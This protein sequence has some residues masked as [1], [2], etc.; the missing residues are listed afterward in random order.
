MLSHDKSNENSVPPHSLSEWVNHWGTLPCIKCSLCSARQS[1]LCNKSK[2]EALPIVVRQSAAMCGIARAAGN[3]RVL[4]GG[5]YV[6]CRAFFLPVAQ[7]APASQ[8]TRLAGAYPAPPVWTMPTC[9]SYHQLQWH[10][11]GSLLFSPVFLMHSH[12]IVYY[13]MYREEKNEFLE[14]MYT[15][16]PYLHKNMNLGKLFIQPMYLSF[17]L[18]ILCN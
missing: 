1:V 6:N 5:N 4:A 7:E 18:H 17:Y 12:S 10:A 2:C 13:T 16:I 14:S 11:V 3:G 8:F 9:S 15:I